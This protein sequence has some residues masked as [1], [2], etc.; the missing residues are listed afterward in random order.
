MPDSIE[1]KKKQAGRALT[2]IVESIDRRP[3]LLEEPK[4]GQFSL[5]ETLERLAKWIEYAESTIAA[6]SSNG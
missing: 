3:D 4:F 5:A 6:P 1:E 2:R